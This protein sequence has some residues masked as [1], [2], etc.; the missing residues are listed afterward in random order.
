MRKDVF[1]DEHE[2][3]NVV[4]DY[5]TF[6]KKMEE[7]KP[8]RVTFEENRTIKPKIY[9]PD[10]AVG[11]DNC[12]LIIVPLMMSVHFLPM[13]EFKRSGLEKKIHFYDQKVV[14]RIS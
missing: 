14:D 6:L 8:Y 2:Q 10:C 4:E 3:S 11:G 7:L 12:R 13:T 1:V 9:L 5:K